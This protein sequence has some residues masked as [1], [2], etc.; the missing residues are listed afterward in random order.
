MLTDTALLKGAAEVAATSWN[1]LLEI[2]LEIGG[3][4]TV[5]A[6]SRC[7]PTAQA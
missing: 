5:T 4:T 3:T 7:C 6:A 2:D 1:T